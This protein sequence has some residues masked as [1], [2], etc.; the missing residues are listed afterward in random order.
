MSLRLRGTPTP[1][2]LRPVALAKAKAAVAEQIDAWLGAGPRPTG[3]PPRREKAKAGPLPTAAESQRQLAVVE[4]RFDTVLRALDGAST[5]GSVKSALENQATRAMIEL[6]GW[7]CLASVLVTP[8]AP[9]ALHRRDLHDQQAVAQ[10]LH[11]ALTAARPNHQRIASLAAK[12]RRSTKHTP[13][14]PG[15]LDATAATVLLDMLGA[16]GPDF[17][18]LIKERLAHGA[19]HPAAG[20]LAPTKSSILDPVP[21]SSGDDGLIDSYTFDIGTNTWVRAKTTPERSWVFD[22]RLAQLLGFEVDGVIHGVNDLADQLIDATTHPL[23]NKSAMAPDTIR[24]FC[25]DIATVASDAK[26][27]ALIKDLL[28]IRFPFTLEATKGGDKPERT[29]WEPSAKH[30]AALLT[31]LEDP[32][33]VTTVAAAA[34]TIRAAS[35][36][37]VDAKLAKLAPVLAKHKGKPERHKRAHWA[38]VNLGQIGQSVFEISRDG[39]PLPKSQTMLTPQKVAQDFGDAEDAKLRFVITDQYDMFV[40]SDEQ[41]TDVGAKY[42]FPPNHELLSYNRPVVATGYVT[43]EHGKIVAIEDDGIMVPGKLPADLP[44]AEAMLGALKF[45]LDSEKIAAASCRVLD[46]KAFALSAPKAKLPAEL[47]SADLETLAEAILE[48][49]HATR[50]PLVAAALVRAVKE[51]KAATDDESVALAKAAAYAGKLLDGFQLINVGIR[52]FADG[53]LPTGADVVDDEIALCLVK[54]VAG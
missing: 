34:T 47:A 17:G 28:A 14:G 33:R 18:A 35:K 32:K 4:R 8:K 21:Q 41:Y 52:A 39:G 27:S 38:M 40:L 7:R 54:K 51:A 25:A 37:R 43:I 6:R 53:E 48:R 46:W 20:H 31:A 12:L 23:T 19:G 45:P 29:I 10:G 24:S 5:S 44:P 15:K 26:S 49:P 36:A 16:G 42:G 3:A 50:A 11:R 13:T 1:V 2:G 22:V 30:L 9:A